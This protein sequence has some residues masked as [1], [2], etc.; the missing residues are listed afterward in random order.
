RSPVLPIFQSPLWCHNWH[1]RSLLLH[2]PIRNRHSSPFP[3]PDGRRR[4][5]LVECIPVGLTAVSPA[6]Q[7]PQRIPRA[8][9]EGIRQRDTFPPSIRRF[10]IFPSDN[11]L[12]F[13]SL[14]YRRCVGVR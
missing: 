9:L 12:P 1:R 3:T 5:L 4:G 14:G 2:H 11:P 13:R 8:P 10:E 7:F 6:G